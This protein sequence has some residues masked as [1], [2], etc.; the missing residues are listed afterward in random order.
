MMEPLSLAFVG[1]LYT[2]VSALAL[3]FGSWLVVGVHFSGALFVLPVVALC[4]ATTYTL[5]VAGTS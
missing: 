1:W 4:A 2:G 5:R 3:A